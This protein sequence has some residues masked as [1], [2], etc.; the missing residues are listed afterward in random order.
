MPLVTVRTGASLY[1]R[2]EGQG[3]PLLLIMGTGL[4]H[5]VWDR[6]VEA[7]APEFDCI[8]FDNR[9][10]GRSDRHSGPL[11]TALLADDAA[12]LLDELGVTKAHV[13]G[14][15]LGSC[16]AQEL[17]LRRPELVRTLQL[18]GTWGR[19]HGYARRKFQA[20]IRLLETMEVRS[21]YEIN[22]LFLYTPEFMARYP[23]EVEARIEAVVRS[24][25]S[26]GLIKA[27]Y[28][29]DLEHDTLDRLP[30][31]AVP[32]LVTVGGFDTAVPPL[33][34]REVAEAVPEAELHV[35]PGG[36][37]LHNVEQPDAFN[38]V[39]LKFLRKHRD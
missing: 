19:A 33:Y 22:V 37:H 35:F 18:H 23:D 9:G 39:T 38:R 10:L 15:S 20:Q 8:R 30:A 5:S 27:Q 4:D 34:A 3:P 1:Y 24:A 6:Q 29:A 17:A 16:I 14:L 25:P 12:G 36:G 28:L 31:V 2:R 26:P 13:S 7:Y 32:T 21:F 11:S